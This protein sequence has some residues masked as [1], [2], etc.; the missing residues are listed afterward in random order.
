MKE[1]WEDSNV[2]QVYVFCL[3]DCVLFIGLA[4]NFHAEDMTAVGFGGGSWPKF[5][6]KCRPL[7]VVNLN[8][9]KGERV[10]AIED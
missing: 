4:S 8:E 1:S 10:G 5:C 9:D 7:N 2:I 6:F 3:N